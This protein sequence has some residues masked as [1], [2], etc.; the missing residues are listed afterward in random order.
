MPNTNIDT[1]L[2][3]YSNQIIEGL[4]N[5]LPALRAFSLDLSEDATKPGETIR[6]PLVTADA[7]GAW[8][9]STRNY[10]RDVTALKDK[11]IVIDQRVIAGFAI[12]QK[13]LHN[14]QPQWWEGKAQLNAIEIA[15]AV[16][17]SILSLVTPNNYGDTAAKKYSVTEADFGRA[18]I[19]GLRAAA[20]KAKLRP[21]RAVLVLNPDFFA[22]LLGDLDANVYGGREAM[23]SGE[24]PGLLGFRAILEA[25][26]LNIPGFLAHPDAIAVASRRVQVADAT[27]YR[28]FSAVTEPDTGLTLNRVVYTDGQTGETSLSVEC[29]YGFGVGNP[30]SLIRLVTG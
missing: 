11:S 26:Q 12:D 2:E 29:L 27:P 20:V 24:I 10:S 3:I 17:T 9:R 30:N 7:A 5:A 15:D 23:L 21:A 28:D 6:V 1:A 14:F 22:A 16:L 18:S 19:A 8:N 25:P 13:Q 4:T